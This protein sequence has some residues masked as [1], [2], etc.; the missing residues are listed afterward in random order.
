MNKSALLNFANRESA[1][2]AIRHIYVHIPFCARICPYCAFYKERADPSH[3]LSFAR[4]SCSNWINTLRNLR[5]SR[6]RFFWRRHTDD[7][8]NRTAVIDP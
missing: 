8:D 7:A 5:F 2:E 6:R 1:P 4:R 3:T